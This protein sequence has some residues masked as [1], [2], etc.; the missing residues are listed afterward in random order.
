MYFTKYCCL[1]LTLGDFLPQKP[2][3]CGYLYVTEG[4]A[5]CSSGGAAVSP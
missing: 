1:H 5:A 4:A 3:L 2:S